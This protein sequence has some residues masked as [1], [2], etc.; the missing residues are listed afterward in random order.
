MLH[1]RFYLCHERCKS[2]SWARLLT[3]KMTVPLWFVFPRCPCRLPYS[4]WVLVLHPNVYCHS[5]ERRHH[6]ESR[7]S[8]TGESKWRGNRFIKISIFGAFVSII[9]RKEVQ[10]IPVLI[11][12]ST[13][14]GDLV[15]VITS[16]KEVMFSSVSV[17]LSEGLGKGLNRF[18][19]NW[20]IH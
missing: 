5:F 4:L 15:T 1:S 17:Y 14:N 19:L 20:R 7:S 3:C 11:F 6:Q 8:K 16:A 2:Q 13:H 12:C 18:A 10:Q 9:Q